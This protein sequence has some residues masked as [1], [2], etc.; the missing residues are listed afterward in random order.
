MWFQSWMSSFLQSH[1]P[2]EIIL[3]FRF[4][5]QKNICCYYYYVENSEVELKLKLLFFLLSIN[6]YN[7]PLPPQ[8]KAFEWYSL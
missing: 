2:S 4:A 5:A 7:S 8:T 6:F 3:I 1:D